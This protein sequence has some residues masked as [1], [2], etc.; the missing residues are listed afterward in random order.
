MTTVV[1]RIKKA[2]DVYDD[3]GIV[4][5]SIEYLTISLLILSFNTVWTRT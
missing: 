2:S 5:A 1:D 4:V 3:C